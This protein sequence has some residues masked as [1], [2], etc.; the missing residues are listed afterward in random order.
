LGGVI[1]AGVVD[2][3]VGVVGV[4]CCGWVWGLLVRYWAFGWHITGSA[5]VVI[6][7]IGVHE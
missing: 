7:A 4:L 5:I 6:G 2:C 1:E 3:G